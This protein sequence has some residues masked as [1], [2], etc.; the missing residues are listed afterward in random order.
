MAEFTGEDIASGS[1]QLSKSKDYDKFLLGL[2]IEEARRSEL[3]SAT[4]LMTVFRDG[5]EWNITGKKRIGH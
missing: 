3:E 2:G 1:Y 4:P 5:D